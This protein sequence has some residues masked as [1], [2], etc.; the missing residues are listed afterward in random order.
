MALPHGVQEGVAPPVPDPQ[1][2]QDL[3]YGAPGD[4]RLYAVCGMMNSDHVVLVVSDG[5]GG[6]VSVIPDGRECRFCSRRDSE[7]DHV[8]RDHPLH[9]GRLP[10]NQ[11]NKVHLDFETRSDGRM[12][13]DVNRK[14]SD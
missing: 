9:W 10:I 11:M 4:H 2:A 5:K 6:C 8:F 7:R 13:R 3:Q 12:A 1:S 14:G